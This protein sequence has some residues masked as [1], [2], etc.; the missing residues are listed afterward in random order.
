M[1]WAKKASDASNDFFKAFCQKYP[2]PDNVEL[3]RSAKMAVW[4]NVAVDSSVSETDLEAQHERA[5]QYLDWVER[6]D[7]ELLPLFQAYEEALRK[8]REARRR[9]DLEGRAKV[10]LTMEDLPATKGDPHGTSSRILAHVTVDGEMIGAPIVVASGPRWDIED[11]FNGEITT[12][13]LRRRL[14]GDAVTQ[15]LEDQ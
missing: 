12:A 4:S 1:D 10:R 13:E 5:V 6:T 2:G 11:Y 14:F 15:D 3:R 8:Y 7:Q 9:R